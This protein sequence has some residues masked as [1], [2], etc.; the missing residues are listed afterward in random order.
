MSCPVVQKSGNICGRPAKFDIYCGIHKSHKPA[1]T[2]LDAPTPASTT[3]A[4]AST[5]PDAPTP[6]STTPEAHASAFTFIELCSGAGGLSSG[7]VKAGLHPLLLNDFNSDCCKTLELNH[8]NV[9][10]ICGS[11]LDI[12]FAPYIG[13]VDLIAAGCPCQSFSMAGNREGFEDGRGNLM[14]SFIRIALSLKPK[15][16][17]IENVTGLISHDGGDTLKTILEM[18]SDNNRYDTNYKTLNAVHYNVCQRRKRVFIVCTLRT[19][20]ENFSYP[21]PNTTKLVLNDILHNVPQSACS[22]FSV[23]K[24]MFLEAIPAGG[25]WKNLPENLKQEFLGNK[26]A[27]SNREKL[28]KLAYD[29][30]SLT[31]RCTPNH[32]CH[33]AETRPFTIREYA[34]IQSFPDSYQ[35]AGSITSIYKQIGNAVP[36]ELAFAIGKSIINF[37]LGIDILERQNNVHKFTQNQSQVMKNQS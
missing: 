5:A 37:L 12:D 24:Q 23:K 1:S 36:V 29:E 16:I 8:P 27:G 35:F 32:F 20:G 2:A 19:F 13:K 28:R 11:M 14:L 4:R 6:A 18:L 9:K 17:L 3:P 10:V 31:I 21:N 34:R 15:I 30:S 33:P 25:S 22:K 26:K 7:L